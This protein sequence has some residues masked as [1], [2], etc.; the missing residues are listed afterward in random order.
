MNLNPLSSH[1]GS[2]RPVTMSSED[3]TSTEGTK[4]SFLEGAQEEAELPESKGETELEEMMLT[5]PA[6]F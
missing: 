6:R 5:K 4:V 3:I 2:H 1:F